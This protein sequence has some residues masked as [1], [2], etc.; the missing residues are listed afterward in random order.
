MT[1]EGFVTVMG[2]DVVRLEPSVVATLI[3]VIPTP[4]ALT[5]PLITVA[6]RLLLDD[7]V[8]AVTV[9]LLGKIVRVKV[10]DCPICKAK[11]VGDILILVAITLFNAAA[12]RTPLNEPKPVQLSYPTPA[13]NPPFEPVTI[14]L[15]Q[16]DAAA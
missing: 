11:L 7:Q 2:I 4:M 5:T 15:K 10:L 14:S 9:T 13:E 8:T 1:V 6:T 16:L 12:K 3:V